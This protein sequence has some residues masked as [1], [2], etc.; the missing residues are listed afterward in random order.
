MVEP[1]EGTFDHPSPRELFP[2][3][4]F[5]FFRNIN[6]KAELTLRIRNKSATI[7]SICTELLDRRIPPIPSFRSKYPTFC[8]MNIGSMNHNRQQTTNSPAHP[9]RCAASCLS[10]FPTVNSTFFAGCYRFYTLGINDRVAWTLLASSVCS[11]L[12]HKML[13]NFIPQPTDPGAA[14]KAVYCR[15]WWKVM[16][17]LSP[18][19]P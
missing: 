6:V 10:F 4:R 1:G 18:F 8:V 3:M 7:S 5:D 19:A 12:F 2:L 14:I 16:G 17:Q 9:L 13:Q 15:I 11:R